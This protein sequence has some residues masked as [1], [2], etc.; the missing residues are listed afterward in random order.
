[1]RLG[2]AVGPQ[3]EAGGALPHCREQHGPRAAGL[4]IGH[5]GL[6][7]RRPVPRQQRFVG[8]A[9]CQAQGA[10]LGRQHQPAG[11]GL[12]HRQPHGARR[13]ATDGL[14]VSPGLELF[15]GLGRAPIVGQARLLVDTQHTQGRQH[16]LG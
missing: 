5:L 1:M 4:D 9:H 10:G 16:Y 15:G 8:T 7:H 2:S 12:G 3:H 14:L 13:I 11:Q 6:A